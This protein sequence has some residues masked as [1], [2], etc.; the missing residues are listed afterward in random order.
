MDTEKHIYDVSL[1]IYGSKGNKDLLKSGLIRYAISQNYCFCGAILGELQKNDYI[2]KILQN[3]TAQFGEFFQQNFITTPSNIL[4]DFYTSEQQVEV[5]NNSWFYKH[6]SYQT[7]HELDNEL[8]NQFNIN[9][10]SQSFF[11]TAQSLLRHSLSEKSS[12]RLYSIENLLK[13]QIVKPEDELPLQIFSNAMVKHSSHR[14]MADDDFSTLLV[15]SILNPSKNCTDTI[16]DVLLTSYGE[17]SRSSNI[18]LKKLI[19]SQ[20]LNCKF[21]TENKNNIYIQ[22]SFSNILG[23]CSNSLLNPME[24]NDCRTAFEYLQHCLKVIAPNYQN[25]PFSLDNLKTLLSMHERDLLLQNI[26]FKSKIHTP[27]AL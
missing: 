5:F 21:K 1:I 20:V 18:L 3:V 9:C 17:P 10:T 23:L 16:K 6:S 27:T 4:Y 26:H 15:Q 2:H 22:N 11:N 19:Q 24:S 14:I 25:S 8:N 12:F 7:L 13:Y